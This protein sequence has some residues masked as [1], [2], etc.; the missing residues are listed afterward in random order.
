MT[1]TE[2]KAH[3]LY[4]GITQASIAREQGVTRQAIN[5]VISRVSRKRAHRAAIAEK[6]CLPYRAVWGENDP[7]SAPQADTQNVGN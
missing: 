3:L 7:A 4:R 5:H 6:L 2:I 1:P